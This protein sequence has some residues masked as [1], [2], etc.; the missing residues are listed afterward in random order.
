[1]TCKELVKL[2]EILGKFKGESFFQYAR[3][4]KDRY[5]IPTDTWCDMV[6]GYTKLLNYA[7]GKEKE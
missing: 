7:L 6:N 4:G 3:Y 1:M 5:S 2:S